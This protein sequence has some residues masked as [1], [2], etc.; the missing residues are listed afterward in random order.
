MIHT[1]E[2]DSTS[3]VSELKKVFRKK[4]M[5]G[6]AVVRLRPGLSSEELESIMQTFGPN[7]EPHS[8]QEMVLVELAKAGQL[9]DSA[10]SKLLELPLPAI[11]R[12]RKSTC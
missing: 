8:L 12:L 10:K 3:T 7:A 11:R 9:T 2:V 6:G 4:L 1:I 5:T